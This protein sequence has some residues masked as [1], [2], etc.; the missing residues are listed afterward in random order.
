MIKG[1]TLAKG[2]SRLPLILGAILG[3]VAAGLVVV[4]LSSAKE[5]GGSVPSGGG[6]GLATVVAAQPISAGTRLSADMLTVKDI[7]QSDRLTDAFGSTEGLVGQVTR[8]PLAQGEQVIPSKVVGTATISEFGGNP[9]LALTVSDGM[10]G[11]SVEVSS[12]IG[13]G[14]NI[15]PGDFVD[16][17]LVVSVKPLIESATEQ[18]QGVTDT[19]ASMILQNVK[20]LAVD[21]EVANPNPDAS[22]DPEESKDSD[23]AATTVTLELTPIQSEVAAMADVCADEHGGRIALSL[24]SVADRN[25]ISQ[26]TEWPNDGPPPSCATVLGISSLGG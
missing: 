16:V 21:T 19:V 1:A 15:R 8:V 10:R 18:E 9:P 23:E 25:E 24:R 13:A 2:G 17:I 11:V 12:L 22:T 6:G 20:V 26:R 14:G 5:E 4:Y 3:L 7:R